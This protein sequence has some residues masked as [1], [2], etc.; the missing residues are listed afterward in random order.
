MDESVIKLVWIGV[1]VAIVIAIYVVLKV[2]VPDFTT[3]L[4]KKLTG[5]VNNAFEQATNAGGK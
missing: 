4:T 1:S 2:F 5:F 3:N